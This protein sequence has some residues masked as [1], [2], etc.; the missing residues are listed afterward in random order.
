MSISPGPLDLHN[1]K[2]IFCMLWIS[3]NIVI[4]SEYN[5]P[6]V[7]RP[8]DESLSILRNV[9]RYCDAHNR[10]RCDVNTDT[11]GSDT[12]AGRVLL[13]VSRFILDQSNVV[14]VSGEPWQ[15]PRPR[16]QSG[17]M[18]WAI[19]S[20]MRERGRNGDLKWRVECH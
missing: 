18:K 10:R 1:I 17:D 7:G 6:R 8:M 14:F 4:L 12:W 5:G 11:G 3:K 9:R 19:V 16:Q 13:K 15:V 2:Q 20:T